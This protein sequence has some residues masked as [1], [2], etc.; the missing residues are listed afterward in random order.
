MT[1][2][3]RPLSRCAAVLASACLIAGCGTA[4]STAGPG[5]T[6]TT[7]TPSTG[8]TTLSKAASV[9]ACHRVIASSPGLT[10]SEKAKVATLCDKAATE[11]PVQ[12]REAAAQICAEL[13]NGSK[14]PA[15]TAKSQA[16]AAC[17][18]A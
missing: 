5:T 7:T 11:N 16:L 10:A 15:G 8:T 17:K 1:P 12:V 14:I 13:V 18:A 9:A 3:V 2:T 4:S 6:P